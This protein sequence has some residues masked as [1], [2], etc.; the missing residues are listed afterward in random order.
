[1]EEWARRRG[2]FGV[3]LPARNMSFVL[4]ALKISERKRSKFARPVYVHPPRPFTARRRRR[5]LAAL[6]LAGAVVL[7]ALTWRLVTSTST[8]VEVQVPAE[9][10]PASAGAPSAIEEI[11]TPVSRTH[12]PVPTK[13][14]PATAAGNGRQA[15]RQEPLAAGTEPARS[16]IAVA[17]GPDEAQYDSPPLTAAPPDWPSLDLQMLYYSAENN[18]SFAQ[19]N[20]RSYG[21][22]EQL[23]EGPEVQEIT[24]D[25]VILAYRGQRVLL[26][27]QK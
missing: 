26:G 16:N 20:G 2:R 3:G 12:A 22:G 10:D 4:D 19:I 8:T 14:A 27:M 17:A 25:G 9:A 1:M 13:A 21:A 24:G 18:G 5:R 23:R 11:G 6:S 15:G 7:V